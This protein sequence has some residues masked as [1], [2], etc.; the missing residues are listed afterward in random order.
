MGVFSLTEFWK[1][2][3]SLRIDTKERGSVILGRTFM[4]S[5]RR[6]INEI[7]KGLENGIHEFVTLKARQLGISTASLALDLYWAGKYRGI[8]GALVVHDEPARD[9]FRTTLEMYYQSLP[10]GMKRKI[11][12]HNR[13][14]LVFE[15][16]TRFQYKVAGTKT[17]S[18]GTLGR[19]S[20][21][22][23]LHATEVA[24]W[25]DPAGIDS[26]V[27]TLAQENP[28]RFY[29]WETTANGFNHFY[30]MWDSAKE[31]I[32]KKAIF[33][34]FWANEMYSAKRDTDVFKAYWGANGRMTSDE[35]TMVKEIKQLYEYDITEEQLAWYRWYLKE[36]ADGSEIQMWQEMPHTEYAAFVASGSQFF[37]ARSIGDAYR[38]MQKE[39]APKYYRFNLGMDFSDTEIMAVHGKIATLKVWAEPEK[40]AQY[41]LGADPAYGSSEESDR[42]AISVWRCYADKIEQVAEFCTAE[43]S[44]ANFAW[45][46]VYLAAA[47]DPCT[48][49]LEINGPGTSVLTELQNMSKSRSIGPET[50]RPAMQNAMKNISSYLYRKYDSL[51]SA[52][53]AIHTM[54]T[55]NVKE[56]YLGA[57]RDYFERGYLIPHSRDLIDEMKGII[58]EDGSTPQAGGRNKD[59]RVIAAGLA[60][61]AWNDQVRSRLMAQN[62]TYEKI[63]QRGTLVVPDQPGVRIVQQL[64]QH[65]GF[66]ESLNK[67]RIEGVRAMVTK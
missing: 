45:I 17:K 21:L 31:S 11:R 16:G 67:P 24:F 41:V 27:A 15:H 36:K 59:D 28:I 33:I 29:H 13:N 39:P 4:G 57:M 10:P 66:T 46:M 26:L 58:R 65:I 6:L 7:A 12:Q 8:S 54:T 42:Y 44:T 53:S 23:F 34:G 37:T 47:Y 63:H 52:P 22:T 49:N 20:A 2:C 56:R 18:A 60:C 1:F 50:M 48:W 5:Q 14:Q 55:S 64:F 32:T 35:R 61:I 40:G 9:Q 51:Y 3:N 19:S 62:A 25:G 38:R 30:D 43:M